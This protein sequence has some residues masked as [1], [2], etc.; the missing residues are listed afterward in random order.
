MDFQDVTEIEKKNVLGF[1]PNAIEIICK[2]KSYY[3]CSFAKRNAVFRLLYSVWKGVS[4]ETQEADIQDEENDIPNEVLQTEQAENDYNEINFLQTFSADHQQEM[5]KVVLPVNVEK[6]FALCISDEAIFSLFDHFQMKGEKDVILSKWIE[7]PELGI[8]TRELN[9]IIKTPENPFKSTS[10]CYKVQSYKKE[11]EKLTI[12]TMTKTL[13]VPYGSCFQLEERWEVIPEA[14][15]KDKCVL[16]CLAW[17]VFNKSTLFK[18][19]IENQGSI[20]IKADYELYIKNLKE[21]K[22]F[23]N[24][25]K[26]KHREGLKQDFEKSKAL[27]LE[28]DDENSSHKDMIVENKEAEKNKKKKN[29][30]DFVEG[31]SNKEIKDLQRIMKINGIFLLI[32]VLTLFLLI[33]MMNMHMKSL[34]SQI[35]VLE[36]KLNKM[37]NFTE[38]I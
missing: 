26:P 1:I 29:S 15:N 32:L 17:F 34:S 11:E 37:R 24:P 28:I 23:E 4:F 30:K 10:R 27:Q 36:E 2:S 3:F 20:S 14:E 6:Y 25:N 18:S 13:D 31:V 38:I 35:G 12:S 7:N 21:K 16:R 33:V 8:H 9:M 19:K 22:V 5:I